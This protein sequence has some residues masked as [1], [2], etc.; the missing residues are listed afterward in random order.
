VGVGRLLLLLAAVLGWGICACVGWGFVHWQQQIWD[1]LL[2]AAG[3][4]NLFQATG[5][6]A[7]K[8]WQLSQEFHKLNL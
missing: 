8:Q 1:I 3:C 2:L 6:H 4:Q 7:K 5:K